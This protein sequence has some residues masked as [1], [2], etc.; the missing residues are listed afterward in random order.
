MTTKLR[1]ALVFALSM[2]TNLAHA[3]QVTFD[4]S[5]HTSCKPSGSEVPSTKDSHQGGV[6]PPGGKTY[7]IHDLCQATEDLTDIRI[8]L[9][10]AKVLYCFYTNAWIRQGGD[11]I[12][13]YLTGIDYV[14]NDVINGTFRA[15]FQNYKSTPEIKG[16]FMTTNA[17]SLIIE[18]SGEDPE[19]RAITFEELQAKKHLSDLVEL[20][21]MDVTVEEDF[22]GTIYSMVKNGEKIQLYNKLRLDMEGVENGKYTVRGIVTLHNGKA[23][24]YPTELIRPTDGVD[25]LRATTKSDR[26]PGWNLMGQRAGSGYKGIII[27]NGKK[28]VSHPR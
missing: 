19:P 5:R 6:T 24:L 10:D 20:K 9:K 7:T 12:M 15:D 21:D 2:L 8:E 25:R 13:L 22:E 1:T 28:V 14:A 16:N 11:A 23:Q 18:N 17:D 27:R 4:L 26:Q 3:E